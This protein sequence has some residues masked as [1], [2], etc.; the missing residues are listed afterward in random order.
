MAE[1]TF[2]PNS[3]TAQLAT[4]IA[5]QTAMKDAMNARM[6]TQDATLGR[7]E[8]QALKTNGRVT[9]LESGVA[10]LEQW[11][12]VLRGKVAVVAAIVG[13]LVAFTGWLIQ[14]LLG[15]QG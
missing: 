2:D 5:Q 15:L 7:I 12:A 8:A 1:G 11:K 9:V 14:I 3:V 13:G 6:D 4:L 10:R